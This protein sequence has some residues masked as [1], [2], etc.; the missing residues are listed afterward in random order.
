MKYCSIIDIIVHVIAARSAT[1][2]L[3][4][5]WG[6]WPIEVIYIDIIESIIYDIIQIWQELL[7]E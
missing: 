2:L 1:L 6:A 7:L 3:G 4:P 5:R